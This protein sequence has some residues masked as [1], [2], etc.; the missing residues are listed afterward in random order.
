MEGNSNTSATTSGMNFAFLNN[1]DIFKES[2]PSFS[3]HG[4]SQTG[5]IFGG[6]TS[7]VMLYITTVFFIARFLHFIERQN[8]TVNTY[9]RKDAFANDDRL[10]LGNDGF[11]LAFAVENYFTQKSLQDPRYVKWFA[12]LVIASD[13]EQKEYELQTNLCRD[14]D[15]EKFYPI[16]ERSSFRLNRMR[17]TEDNQLFCIDW[18]S[19]AIDLY[20]T[21]ATGNYAYIDIIILPCN[22]K[23]SEITPGSDDRI[24]PECIWDLEKQQEYMQPPAL[25]TLHNQER[26]NV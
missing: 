15:F 13:G 7:I 12:T 9:Q 2:Y 11:R 10:L 3:L 18:E 22:V 16:E 25:I 6:I 4:R 1:A 21:E 20:G 5:T 17:T 24:H 26:V 14:E 19:A 23:L 8:P